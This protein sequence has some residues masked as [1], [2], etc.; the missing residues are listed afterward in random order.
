[1]S[2][3]ALWWN[4]FMRQKSCIWRSFTHCER[5]FAWALCS[6]FA[7]SAIRCHEVF[8]HMILQGRA[9]A[10]YIHAFI[11]VYVFAYVQINIPVEFLHML[12]VE[13]D[14]DIRIYK[15][16]ASGTYFLSFYFCQ[17]LNSRYGMFIPVTRNL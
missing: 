16:M 2:M 9:Y 6:C 4:S 17:T 7:D 5:V 14:I 15:L 10:L 3:G 13:V 11:L 12:C 1:M 8:W